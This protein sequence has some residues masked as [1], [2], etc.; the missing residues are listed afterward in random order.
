MFNYIRKPPRSIMSHVHTKERLKKRLTR[1]TSPFTAP[2]SPPPPQQ[3]QQSDAYPDIP[4]IHIRTVSDSSLDQLVLDSGSSVISNDQAQPYNPGSTTNL[5][6]LSTTRPS[7]ISSTSS[8]S[9]DTN[10]SSPLRAYTTGNASIGNGS[11]S[12]SNPSAR[13]LSAKG[14]DHAFL[15]SH[16]KSSSA[17][18]SQVQMSIPALTTSHSSSYSSNSGSSKAK[19]GKAHSANGISQPTL[20]SIAPVHPNESLN[21][22][23]ISMM[24]P[25]SGDHSHAPGSKTSSN[26]LFNHMSSSTASIS[27]RG[28][29]NNGGGGLLRKKNG[30]G[31]MSGG[32]PP[33]INS[34][35]VKKKLITH[36]HSHHIPLRCPYIKKEFIELEESFDHGIELKIKQI[37]NENELIIEDINK[38]STHLDKLC[39]QLEEQIN[40]LDKFIIELDSKSFVLNEGNNT[41]MVEDMNDLIKRIDLVTL[42]INQKKESLTEI[43]KQIDILQELKKNKKVT[44]VKRR[45]W[46][47]LAGG[48]VT[49]LLVIKLAFL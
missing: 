34:S 26:K 4:K 31:S 13:Y 43:H 2:L 48:L 6:Y 9:I 44:N 37:S 42:N 18:Q 27:N 41:C 12:N 7:T 23:P 40:E 10:Y 33:H 39:S 46:V 16:G 49:L 5:Q 21:S 3:Q 28:F 14:Q 11:A 1:L 45:K 24:N 20:P 17:N 15:L 36:N 38:L 25:I 8:S 47:K 22:L 32:V 35:R 29:A 19:H 30:G